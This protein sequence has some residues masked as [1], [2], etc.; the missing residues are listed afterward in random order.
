MQGVCDEDIDYIRVSVHVWGNQ[1]YKSS[2]SIVGS[3]NINM[4]C[5]DMEVNAK[6]IYRKCWK[7]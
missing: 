7:W 1:K 2:S 3:S 5:G 6:R 4:S